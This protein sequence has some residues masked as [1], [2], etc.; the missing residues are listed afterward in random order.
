MS[1]K[2][3]PPRKAE[4][5]EEVEITFDELCAEFRQLCV[6]FY[7]NDPHATKTMHSLQSQARLLVKNGDDGIAH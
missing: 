7:A 1:K 6:L 5:S 2:A 3:P 4:E